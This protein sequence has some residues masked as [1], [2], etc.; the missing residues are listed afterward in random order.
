MTSG[1]ECVAPFGSRLMVIL[2]SSLFSEV[3]FV[4]L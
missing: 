2:D 3:F 1:V 4:I